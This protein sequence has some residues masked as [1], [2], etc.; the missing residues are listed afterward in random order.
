MHAAI[1]YVARETKYY[2]LRKS[3][4]LTK[5]LKEISQIQSINSKNND[6]HVCYNEEHADQTCRVSDSTMTGFEESLMIFQTFIPDLISTMTFVSKLQ[7]A[8]FGNAFC[9]PDIG[10][11]QNDY[12]T[13]LFKFDL[14]AVHNDVKLFL[15]N[16]ENTQYFDS[17]WESF[18]QFISS[19]SNKEKVL[20][21]A[22]TEMQ[23]QINLREQTFGTETKTS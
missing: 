23:K 1:S 20:K 7:K 16:N 5:A 13:A 19:N 2:M 14:E 22:L 6:H 3:V 21:D 9:L 8:E 11:K 4:P 18:I 15:N 12:I 10:F 17:L